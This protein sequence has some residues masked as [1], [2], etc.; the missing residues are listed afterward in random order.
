M[1]EGVANR[2]LH[3][4]KGTHQKVHA[5]KKLWG[6]GYFRMSHLTSMIKMYYAHIFSHINYGIVIWGSMLNS[7][8]LQD[9]CRALKACLCII[10]TNKKKLC[11]NLLEQQLSTWD[12]AKLAKSLELIGTMIDALGKNCD[13]SSTLVSPFS[14]TNFYD[15]GS[16]AH[17]GQSAILFYVEFS[18]FTNG[19][20]NQ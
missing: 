2:A 16:P 4:T 3:S 1:K 6:G 14:I 20:L 17:A 13:S 19:I 11:C 10:K 7:S 18:G 8:S 5:W 12:R 15:I 9:L